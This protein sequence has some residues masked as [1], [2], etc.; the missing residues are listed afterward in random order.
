[1]RNADR[2]SDSHAAPLKWNL[3]QPPATTDVVDRGHFD[4]DSLYCTMSNTRDRISR[5]QLHIRNHLAERKEKRVCENAGRNDNRGDSRYFP[6]TLERREHSYDIYF[7]P[8][9]LFSNGGR[10]KIP[11]WKG[12]KFL[13]RLISNGREGEI[14]LLSVDYF[15]TSG[16]TIF[17]RNGRAS[18]RIAHRLACMERRTESLEAR[19]N[20]EKHRGSTKGEAG[21][22]K[23]WLRASITGPNTRRSYFQG[24]SS[25]SPRRGEIV[26]FSPCC[27]GRALN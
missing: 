12:A 14:R 16:R 21:Y 6:E 1:M 5:N 25:T 11:K 26:S 8:G 2:F 20:I 13:K 7:Y 3:H 27:T 9:Q 19:T 24:D 22:F 23:A 18:P 10:G 15:Y 4:I 17:A